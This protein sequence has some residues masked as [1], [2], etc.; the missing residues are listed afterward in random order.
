[1]G[2][3]ICEDIM[4]EYP[5]LFDVTKVVAR[6]LEQMVGLPIQDSEVAYLALHFGAHL[7]TETPVSDVLRVMIVCA[8][9]ISTGKMLEWEVQRLLPYVRIVGVTA[10]SNLRNAQDL[11][12]LIISTVKVR[13]VVPSLLV[14]SI[15]TE[16]DRKHIL[17]HWLVARYHRPQLEDS[18]FEAV[19]KYVKEADYKKL[20]GD[21]VNCLYEGG[22]PHDLEPSKG[23]GRLLDYLSI[24]KVHVTE[25]NFQWQDSIRFTGQCLVERGSIDGEYLEEIIGRICRYGNY[26]FLTDEV[27]LAHAR[28]DRDVYRMDVALTV[29]KNPVLFPK[30]RGVQAGFCTGG[31]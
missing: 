15:L 13:S 12:D 4:R 31:A 7:K 27:V 5:N 23:K 1:M 19:K 11:C 20:R 18:L 6:Y 30:N 21:I 14:H 17:N 2:S 25:E 29:F 8:S 24:A 9:G 22:E 26:M 10:A 3:S 16:E 28:P